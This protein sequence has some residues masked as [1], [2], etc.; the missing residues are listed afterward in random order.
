MQKHW[1]QLRKLIPLAQFEKIG[2]MGQTYICVHRNSGSNSFL[3]G[4]DNVKNA[5]RIGII[6][7]GTNTKAKHVPGFKAIEGVEV[8]SVCNRSEHSSRAAAQEFDIPKVFTNW[9]D[10]VNDDEIDAVCIGTWPY[11]HFPITIEA[12]SAGKHVLTEARMALDAKEAKLMLAKSRT[13]PNLI[14]QIVPG[15]MSLPVDETIKELIAENYIGNL[16][17]IQLNGAQSTFVDPNSELH[18]RNERMLSGYNILTMGIWYESVLRWVGP[19][20]KVTAMSQ[21]VQN[22]RIGRDG[23][24]K[25]VDVP[26]HVEVV[27]EM[28]FGGLGH[29]RFSSVTGFARGG[30][31]WIFGSNGTLFFD[32]KTL[33][34]YGGQNGQEALS[35]IHI[36]ENK[37]GFWRVEEEFINAIRGDEIVTHTTF[38]DGVRYMEFTEAVSKSV[39]LGKAISLPL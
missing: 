34:L 37:K 33:K 10:L 4:G 6:G 32:F 22:T 14:T 20:K 1:N 7:L 17:S 13:V 5:V 9:V 27:C 2:L 26:D 38:E 21:I 25:I 16:I 3:N 18:W 30:E 24:R 35:E 31:A 39:A 12:L 28:G 36:P 15:P 23:Q 19:A 11:M 29:F 8:V